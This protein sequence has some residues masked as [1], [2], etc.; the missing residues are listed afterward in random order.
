M[1]W[2]GDTATCSD[3]MTPRHDVTGWHR[4]QTL[5]G[6]TVTWRYR[7]TPRHDVTG[8]HRD[9]TWQGD[10]ATWRYR[11]TPRHDVTGWHRDMTRQGDTTTCRDRVTCVCVFTHPRSGSVDPYWTYECRRKMYNASCAENYFI[12][13]RIQDDICPTETNELFLDL[14]NLRKFTTA[15]LLIETSTVINEQSQ[16]DVTDS[17]RRMFPWRQ[18]RHTLESWWKREILRPIVRHKKNTTCKVA[19]RRHLRVL[20]K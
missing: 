10:T 13:R 14:S 17:R 4:D 15:R 2:Q 12:M 3:R 6:D 7:V 18:W 1:T 8:W 20:D 5:Q 9:M 11:V 16:D 19:N